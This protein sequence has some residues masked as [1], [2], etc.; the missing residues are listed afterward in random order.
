MPGRSPLDHASPRWPSSPTCQLDSP[1]GTYLRHGSE[2][3]PSRAGWNAGS[4]LFCK[5]A[6]CHIG[7]STKPDISRS[8]YI[9]HD[10]S[11]ITGR[12][13]RRTAQFHDCVPTFVSVTQVGIFAAGPLRFS[14]Y[15]H[16]SMGCFWGNLAIS[17]CVSSDNRF[18]F[19]TGRLDISNCVCDDEQ[20]FKR[21]TGTI[22]NPLTR[23]FFCC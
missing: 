15:K 20:A 19:L 5:H 17:S 4:W 1:S 12:W 23:C 16:D 3:Q 11:Y 18:L 2:V 10:L 9:S 21:R 14:I 13:R 7:I 8:R 6:R 22:P